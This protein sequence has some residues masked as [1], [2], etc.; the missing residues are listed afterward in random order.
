MIEIN[1]INKQTNRHTDRQTDGQTERQALEFKMNLLNKIFYEI[2][3]I[4]W[5]FNEQMKIYRNKWRINVW[6]T[7]LINS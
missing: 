4:K 2:N 3:T 1:S 6:I 7:E 5:K